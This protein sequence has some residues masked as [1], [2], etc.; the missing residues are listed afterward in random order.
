MCHYGN[1]E[2]EWTLNK[3]KHTKLTVEKKTLPLLLPGFELATFWSRVRHSNQEA[4]PV[5]CGINGD[6]PPY[7]AWE[8]KTFQGWGYLLSFPQR[9]RFWAGPTGFA[10]FHARKHSNHSFSGVLNVSDGMPGGLVKQGMQVRPCVRTLSPI[11][12]PGSRRSTPGRTPF[13]KTSKCCAAFAVGYVY[14]WTPGTGWKLL[15]G[16]FFFFFS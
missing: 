13:Y 8:L 7:E 1:T 14:L 10:H 5:P 4:I 9:R 2:V 15:E 12:L 16:F 11:T 6:K 3:S